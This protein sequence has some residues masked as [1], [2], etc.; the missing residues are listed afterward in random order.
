[1]ARL[2]GYTTY[3]P[4]FLWISLGVLA[5]GIMV[6]SKEPSVHDETEETT[7]HRVVVE[8]PQY[9]NARWQ[10]LL[11]Y[12]QDVAMAAQKLQPFG[13]KWID[14]LAAAYFVLNDKVY[15]GPILEKI[16]KKAED[17]RAFLE[18][19]RDP[20]ILGRNIVSIFRV[21]TGHVV[22][23]RNGQV[24]AIFGNEV[25]YYK[26]IEDYREATRDQ[27]QWDVVESEDDKL[28]FYNSATAALKKMNEQLG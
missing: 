26:T 8:T 3:Q 23:L 4:I 9:D 13:K 19:L 22:S 5:V 2:S 1:L 24:A 16:H 11:K 25:W 28:D 20:A 14:E 12:D 18:T 17:E 27:N 10:A 7:R 15:L 21:G 6:I